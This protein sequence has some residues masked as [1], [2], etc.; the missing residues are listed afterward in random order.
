MDTQAEPT[1]SGLRR[2]Y[3]LAQAA[4]GQLIDGIMQLPP[5]VGSGSIQVLTPEPDLWLVVHHCTLQQPLTIKRLADATQPERLLISFNAF[6]PVPPPGVRHLSSVQITSSDIDFTITLPA[7]TTLFIVALS[8]HKSLL[9][10]WLDPTDGPLPALLTTRQP[11]VSETLLTPDI[12]RIL[13]DF[14]Q[15]YAKPYLPSFFYKIRIQELLYWLF[16]ELANRTTPPRFLHSADVEKIYQAR[17][18]LLTSL[19]TPPS[20]SG[21]AQAVGLSE[22]KLKQLF[23]QIF[24][25]SPYAFYQ[26]ARLEE[27]RRLLQYVSVSEA[28]YQLGFTNLSHFARLFTKQYHLSPKKYQATH[29]Q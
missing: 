13:A 4:G 2:L 20:L 25:I 14:T 8:I 23:K 27:A 10:R 26:L 18:R 3:E 5:S 15:S 6:E 21:L 24:G 29:R 12:Q 1:A 19:S 7:H 9:R 11:V 28:G 22:A 16:V 17:A